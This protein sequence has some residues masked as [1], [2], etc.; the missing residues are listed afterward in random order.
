MTPWKKEMGE[1]QECVCVSGGFTAGS[2]DDWLHVGTG[3]T[4]AEN[5]KYS[6]YSNRALAH[7]AL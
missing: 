7:P 1:K 2:K 3:Y 4:Q 6:L 5:C